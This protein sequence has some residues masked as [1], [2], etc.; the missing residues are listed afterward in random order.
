MKD[1]KINKLR[2]QIDI[3]DEKILNLL[4]ERLKLSLLIAKEK[5]NKNLNVYDQMRENIIINSLKNKKHTLIS[6]DFI[7]K[8]YREILNNSVCEMN[9]YITNEKGDL[10]M[11]VYEESLKKHYEL[12]GKLEIKSRIQIDNLNNLSLA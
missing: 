6:D 12:N 9:K 2:S 3:I 10:K 11:D 7:E 8:I 4:E 1:H 5:L